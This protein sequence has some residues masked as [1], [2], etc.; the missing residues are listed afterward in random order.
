MAIPHRIKI[1]CILTI[2]TDN[3]SVVLPLKKDANSNR[4][5][6]IKM[7]WEHKSTYLKRNIVFCGNI[8][9]KPYKT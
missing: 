3:F 7:V 4:L 8:I 2:M 1:L 6:G 9:A 5:I